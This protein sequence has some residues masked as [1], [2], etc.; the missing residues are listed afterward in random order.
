MKRISIAALT[1]CVCLVPAAWAQKF[2]CPGKVNWT[3]FLNTDMARN[4]PCEKV[5]NVDNVGSLTLLWT[6]TTGQAAASSP[7][8][9]NEWCISARGTTTYTR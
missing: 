8:V 5:L 1:L 7:A 6:Y 9:V 4:N 3:E 2:T